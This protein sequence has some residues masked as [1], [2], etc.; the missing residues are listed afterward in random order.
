VIYC[1][2]NKFDYVIIPSGPGKVTLFLGETAPLRVEFPV[3]P[4]VELI[5]VRKNHKNR[6]NS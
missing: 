4:G 1:Y 6:R 2:R 3:L 5:K